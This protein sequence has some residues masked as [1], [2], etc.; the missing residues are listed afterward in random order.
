MHPLIMRAKAS[1]EAG[2]A[3]MLAQ[4]C[5]PNE[6]MHKAYGYIDADMNLECQRLAALRIQV[7]MKQPKP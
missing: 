7:A 5:S 6:A 2:Y 4:G 1:A 3:M